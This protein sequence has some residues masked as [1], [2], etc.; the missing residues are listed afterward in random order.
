MR[1]WPKNQFSPIEPHLIFTIIKSYS[2]KHL[3]VKENVILGAWRLDY[4]ECES[5]FFHHGA[6]I[7]IKM[8]K[9]TK[10]NKVI[11]RSPLLYFCNN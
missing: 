4:F 1:T 11:L 3:I 5:V 6:I 10:N 9:A 7:Q 8:S 2:S